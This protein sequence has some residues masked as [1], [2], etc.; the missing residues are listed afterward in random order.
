MRPQDD[1]TWDGSYVATLS[2]LASASR[3]LRDLLD[4]VADRCDAVVKDIRG[5]TTAAVRQRDALVDGNQLRLDIQ[6]AMGAVEKLVRRMRS[7][8]IRILVDS[9]QLSLAEVARLLGISSTMAGRLY[10]AAATA[11]TP[12]SSPAPSKNTRRTSSSKPVS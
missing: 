7:E 5:G 4:V 10:R 9:G 8:G 2:E 11:Q 1:A 3:H 12:S 6:N